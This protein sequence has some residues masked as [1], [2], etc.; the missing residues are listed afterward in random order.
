MCAGRNDSVVRYSLAGST[1]PLAVADYTYDALPLAARAAIPTE[2]ELTEA[3][4]AALDQFI[5]NAVLPV[6]NND[7]PEH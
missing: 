2:T 1:A 5:A 4:D 7:G 3:A 6:G